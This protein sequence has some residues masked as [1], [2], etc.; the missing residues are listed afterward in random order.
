MT[1]NATQAKKSRS[2][3]VGDSFRLSSY[4]SLDNRHEK[5]Y[6]RENVLIVLIVLHEML[7]NGEFEVVS[8]I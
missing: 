2:F 3:T 1:Q 7:Q 8:D 4:Y 6:S 5:F